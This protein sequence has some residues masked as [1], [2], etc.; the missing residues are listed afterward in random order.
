M[1]SYN[2]PSVSDLSCLPF[3][4]P[5]SPLSLSSLSPPTLFP[6][7]LSL[8]PLVLSTLPFSLLSHSFLSPKSPLSLSTNTFYLLLLYLP[9]LPFYFISL[10][11]ST[12][13]LSDIS[14]QTF[15]CR[16]IIKRFFRWFKTRKRTFSRNDILRERERGRR[17]ECA[18]LRIT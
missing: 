6:F 4:S 7:S 1:W 13:S 5:L 9:S 14:P 8:C 2:M 12:L 17:S 11:L 10:S 18:F 3:L 15:F 16:V